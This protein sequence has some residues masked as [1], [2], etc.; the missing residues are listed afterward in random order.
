[1]SRCER[2]IDWER[3]GLSSTC[4]SCDMSDLMNT[5]ANK[6]KEK[7]YSEDRIKQMGYEELMEVYDE[8]PQS[9]R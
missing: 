6:L 5:A 8:P 2:C 3:M 9:Q 7:G 1:M 4:P